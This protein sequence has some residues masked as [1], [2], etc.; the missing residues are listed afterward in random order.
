[1][2]NTLK[3]MVCDISNDEEVANAIALWAHAFLARKS[4][5]VYIQHFNIQIPSS[6]VKCGILPLDSILG[7]MDCLMGSLHDMIDKEHEN[8]TIK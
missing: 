6:N 5:Q 2:C 7:L 4:W 8:T 1:M 3:Q